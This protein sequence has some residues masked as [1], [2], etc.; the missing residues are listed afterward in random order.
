MNP[1]TTEMP[2][3]A[4]E[5]RTESKRQLGRH[6]YDPNGPV[7]LPYFWERRPRVMPRGSGT[8][9]NPFLLAVDPTARKVFPELEGVREVKM[10]QDP[11]T[12]KVSGRI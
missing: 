5:M 7:W 8:R 10:W 9:E 3:W 12:L 1:D 2:E 6:D 4:K 11:E